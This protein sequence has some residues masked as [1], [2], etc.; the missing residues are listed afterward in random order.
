MR[1]SEVIK[2]LRQA[3]DIIE[4]ES[5]VIEGFHSYAHA[6]GCTPGRNVFEFLLEDAKRLRSQTVAP[7]P[8]EGR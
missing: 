7:G 6:H 2:A 8:Q 1:T 3:A 4:C 5:D